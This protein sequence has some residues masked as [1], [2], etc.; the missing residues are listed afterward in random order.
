MHGDSGISEQRIQLNSKCVQW[1]REVVLN[2]GRT[3]LQQELGTYVLKLD[4]MVTMMCDEESM[5][6]V[7]QNGRNV[8]RDY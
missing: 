7:L 6:L 2:G 1:L 5:R 4:G 8:G 3:V